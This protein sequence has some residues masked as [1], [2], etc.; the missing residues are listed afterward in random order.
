MPHSDR[1]KWA[2]GLDISTMSQKSDVDY[3]FWVGCAGSYDDR[4]KKVSRSIAKIMQSADISFSI[5]GTEEKCNGDTA[6]RLGNEYLANM[7]IQENVETFKKYNVKKVVTG[8]PHCFNTI[9]NEYPEFGYKAEVIHH[10]ELIADLVNTGKLN[11]TQV[12]AEAKSVTY[13][14]SC[15]LGRHNDVYEEPR[16]AITTFTKAPIKEMERTKEKGFCCGAGGGRSGGPRREGRDDGRGDRG[17]RPPRAEGERG[18][19][20]PRPEGERGPRPERAPKPEGE[21]V[22]M[23]ATDVPNAAESLAEAERRR[24]RRRRK[25]RGERGAEGAVTTSPGAVAGPVGVSK[26]SFFARMAARVKGWF[27]G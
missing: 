17:P 4:Y 13:H 7:A 11:A 6:R 20:P 24:R 12:P 9:K 1:A 5:L 25:P 2:D 26:D 14:D 27:G 23:Q 16:K 10:S 19:R 22:P 21:A 8:C 15:Y 18:P 3:L